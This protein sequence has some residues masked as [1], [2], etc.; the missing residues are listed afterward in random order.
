MKAPE[1]NDKEK[2]NIV[3][4]WFRLFSL[5]FHALKKWFYKKLEGTYKLKSTTTNTHDIATR[6]ILTY[7]EYYKQSLDLKKNYYVTEGI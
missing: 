6:E 1:E 7:K 4:I 3:T 2:K 5:M